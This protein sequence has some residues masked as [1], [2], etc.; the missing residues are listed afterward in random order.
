MSDF[1]SSTLKALL[2]NNCQGQEDKRVM[3]DWIY[4]TQA[5]IDLRQA[6]YSCSV[7]NGTPTLQPLI[8]FGP[9]LMQ[10]ISPFSNMPVC[11]TT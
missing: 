5:S 9:C 3:I 10:Q 6:A 8:A 7:V 2:S 1:G 11:Y 4:P